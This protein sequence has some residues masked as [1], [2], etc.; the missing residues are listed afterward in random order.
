MTDRNEEPRPLA[1]RRAEEGAPIEDDEQ[2]FAEEHTP[3]D[4]DPPNAP[5][6]TPGGE[7]EGYGPQTEVP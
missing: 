2:D 3:G 6:R 1:D 7:D 5:A 4:S